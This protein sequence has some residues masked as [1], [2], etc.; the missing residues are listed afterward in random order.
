MCYENILTKK[1]INLVP[2]FLTDITCPGGYEY[3]FRNEPVKIDL[4]TEIITGRLVVV[5][6]YTSVGSPVGSRPFYVSVQGRPYRNN[7]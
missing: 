7:K 2:V 3:L 5:F 4:Y 1:I 6:Q